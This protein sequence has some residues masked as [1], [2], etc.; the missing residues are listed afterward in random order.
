MFD[1]LYHASS[2]D[3]NAAVN[4]GKPAAVAAVD[5]SGQEKRKSGGDTGT[6]KSDKAQKGSPESVES[7]HERLD[8]DLSAARTYTGVTGG[9]HRARGSP[10]GPVQ[11]AR[12]G[13]GQFPRGS[14]RGVQIATR[15]AFVKLPSSVGTQLPE[16]ERCCCSRRHRRQR[17]TASS[18]RG[19]IAEAPTPLVRVLPIP[20]KQ[21]RCQGTS[22]EQ[23]K[24]VPTS[25][26]SKRA[27]VYRPLRHCVVDAIGRRRY[28]SPGGDDRPGRED[29]G[30]SVRANPAHVDYVYDDVFVYGVVELLSQIT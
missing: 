9:V 1:Y 23:R 13:V 29:E 3:H 28:R 25:C 16:F 5:R 14:P 15:A 10:A 19:S 8:A 20:H 12:P 30:H 26:A 24:T 6:K 7:S 2:L 27:D 4:V 11:D 17:A 21:N 22:R 18:T